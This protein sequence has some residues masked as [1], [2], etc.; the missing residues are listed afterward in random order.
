MTHNYAQTNNPT[1]T[2]TFNPDLTGNNGSSPLST[3]GAGLATFLLGYPSS[4]SGGAPTPALVAG[5]QFYA[6]LFA[7]DDWH[8]TPK[9]T[10]NLGLRWEHA[11]PWTERFDRLSFFNPSQANSVLAARGINNVPGNIDLVNSQD[12]TYRSN[13]YPNWHQLA[14]RFGFAYQ[15]A[16]KTVHPR[17]IWHILASQ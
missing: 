15:L 16:P 6:A 8:V 7:N 13:I 10:V 5:Q 3:T 11:G 2:F 4:A 14:P 1:G 9:L 17:R 12:D